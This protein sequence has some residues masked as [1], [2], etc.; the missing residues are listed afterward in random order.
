MVPLE[1]L[2]RVERREGD[3]A[4]ARAR[5]WAF[6]RACSSSV[7]PRSVVPS[8]ASSASR[9]IAAR[10]SHAS[11]RAPPA[12]GGSSVRPSERSTSRTASMKPLSMGAT[13]APRSAMTA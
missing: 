11:R 4:H 1:A 10:A 8:G 3:G 13:D 6:A 2:R 5:R 12:C 7:K 9:R